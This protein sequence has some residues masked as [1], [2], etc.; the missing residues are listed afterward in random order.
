MEVTINQHVYQLP[1]TGTLA[2]ALVVFG[3]EQTAGI[4]VA[5]NNNIIPKSE[6]PGF[7]LQSSDAVFII[8]ATQ[9]G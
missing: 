1:D 3:I 2:D 6:W 5:V 4:A 8:R 7:L 9:G